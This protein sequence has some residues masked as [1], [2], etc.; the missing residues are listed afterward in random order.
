MKASKLIK[1]L[2]A[3]H[4]ELPFDAEITNGEFGIP[5]AQSLIKIEHGAPFIVL[6]FGEGDGLKT[7]EAIATL[8]ELAKETPFD[9]T[10]SNARLGDN[11]S[12]LQAVYHEP[13][14]TIVDFD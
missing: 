2:K 4:A 7:S 14:V 11:H 3:I 5:G 8:E 10:I 1:S 9:P 12:E 6:R 13:P